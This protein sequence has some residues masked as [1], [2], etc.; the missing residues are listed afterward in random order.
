[1]ALED[2]EALA[3]P[4]DVDT[5]ATDDGV[6][7]VAE[8]DRVRPHGSRLALGR[9]VRH[10]RGELGVSVADRHRVRSAAHGDLAVP[11]ADLDRVRAVADGDLLVA[12]AGLDRGFS[13]AAAGDL[14]V[15]VAGVDRRVCSA[16]R[17]RVVAGASA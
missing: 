12:V 13:V 4:G 9:T 1:V 17:D 15:A 7:A 8:T 11:L 16:D 2:V 6:V 10:D 5:R 14:V 3:E